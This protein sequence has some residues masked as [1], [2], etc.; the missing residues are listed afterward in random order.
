MELHRRR[1]D[2]VVM[3]NEPIW[4]KARSPEVE[5]AER[6]PDEEDRRGAYLVTLLVTGSWEATSRTGKRR[7]HGRKDGPGSQTWGGGCR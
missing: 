1:G 4:R 6:M 5:K 7:D 3:R 2:A